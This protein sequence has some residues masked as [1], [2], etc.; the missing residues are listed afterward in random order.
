ML[1][2]CLSERYC[3]D[4]ELG[5]G[6][7][8][9]VYRAHDILLDRDVAVKL[10]SRE[11]L[12]SEGRSRLLNEARAAA[13]LN[14]PNIVAV[15]DV[16]ESEGRP[17]I[18]MELV[19]GRSLHELRPRDLAQIL[20]I[21]RQVAEA[22]E[23]AHTHGIVHRDLK[24]ENVMVAP[25]EGGGTKLL[26]LGLARSPASRVSVEGAVVGTAFYLAPEQA[27]GQEVDGR[28]DL[29][30]LGVMLYELVTGRLPFLGDDLLAIISQHL[31]ASPVPPGAFRPGLPAELEAVILRLM[32]K[33]PDERPASAAEVARELAAIERKLDSARPDAPEAAPAPG[34]TLSL[35][36]QLNRG[37]LVGRRAELD[38]LR[39]FW[40]HAHQGH[41][42]L[43]L[44]SGEPGVGK[45]RLAREMMVYARLGGGTVLEGGCY[46]YEMAVPYLP[47]VEALR[48]WVH[49]QDD[50]ALR[51]HLAASAPELARLAPEIE[52]RLGPLPPSP[53]LP[54]NEERL[55]LFD[56]LARLFQRLAAG[57]GLLLFL[58]DLHWADQGT[59]NLLRYLLRALRNDPVMILGA[60]RE[61]ELDRAH[62]LSAAL[63]EWNRA[64]QA[65]RIPL[66]RLERGE[67]AELL[68]ALFGEE[69]VTDE[70]VQA[71]YR[72]TEGNPF[73][74]EEVVK[75]LVEQ[76]QIYRQGGEWER[77]EVSDLAIPQSVKEAI[78]RR[79]SRL[80][81]GCLE[82][83]YTAAPLGKSFPYRE[84][85]AVASGDGHDENRLLDALDEALAAQLLRTAGG[86]QFAFTHDKIRE[87]LIEELNPIRRRRLH[88]RIA[89]ALEALY[90]GDPA[91]NVQDLAYHFVQGGDRQRALVYMRRAAQAAAAVYAHDEALSFYEQARELAED[92]NL[93]G[94][95]AAIHEAMAEAYVVRG[96]AEQAAEHY[97]L[98]L[99]LS[100]QPAE[101]TRLKALIGTVY[102]SIGDDRAVEYLQAALAELDPET[103]RRDLARVLT[104]LGRFEHYHGQHHRAVEFNE[105]A[106][107]L[108]EPLDDAETLNFIYGHLAGAYQH[109][110]RY[111]ES[112]VWARED[113]A[114]GKRKD[115]LL[116]IMIGYEFL[117]E[118]SFSLGRW[119]DALRYAALERELAERTGA[120][121][122]VAW[123]HFSRGHAHYGLGDLPA[124]RQAL[125]E[126]LTLA[127]TAGELRLA[128]IAGGSLSS[129]VADLDLDDEAERL[130][131]ES[132]ARAE[133]LGQ[134][135]MLCMGRH[136]LGYLHT[137]RGE[138]AAAGELYRECLAL[139]AGTDNQV[140]RLS[141]GAVVGEAYLGSGLVDEA[142]AFMEDYL[143]LVAAAGARHHEAWGLRVQGQVLAA[144]GAWEEALHTLDQAVARLEAL[145]SRLEWGRALYHRALL[146]RD[147]DRPEAAARD[148][149]RALDLFQACGA[150]RD[151]RLAAGDS[152]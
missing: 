126:A 6:G 92:L 52:A 124:A 135:Y 121:S 24:P 99:T 23:H 147:R 137:R 40:A 63:V 15:Y 7:M 20:P 117:A 91:P 53:S 11:G 56:Q 138:W 68:A 80:S 44:I 19:E 102:T 46:E 61:V 84:L 57:A 2:T 134:V 34:S 112:M 41:L 81:T 69:Q 151:A 100:L 101:R 149:E 49:T 50:D 88:L 105:R 122:R 141:I 85:A 130:A 133:E 115:F 108:A 73:F 97:R 18:V 114:L 1:G 64:R 94:E 5:H 67:T 103:Q 136:A 37:R 21:V 150:R 79:L 4:D 13:R 17:F 3:L 120:Q 110:A 132:L 39:S 90:A 30:A 12:G 59:L 58:D 144:R 98:A 76:G 14:H 143:A 51:A 65:V 93:P 25:A 9:T 83:L 82:V 62:P 35:L 148:L 72:E 48:A 16:G 36:Q 86:E 38:Q 54:A 71:V 152:S 128:V 127:E 31:H 142:A 140:N 43:P 131:R 146:H 96:P 32:A 66:G 116:A 87:V 8:G 22:L 10:V 77:M 45:T 42:Q 26:D 70:F 33:E 47:F 109:L 55:R 129:V 95:Q 75:A 60:Y 27:L 29:Y 123:S 89:E 78:G 74:V 111:E 28:A 119:H 113:V 145:G 106:L 104:A 118:D 139:N 107:D 125:A